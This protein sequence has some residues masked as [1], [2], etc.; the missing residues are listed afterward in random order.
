M[1]RLARCFGVAFTAAL[2]GW[3]VFD[4]PFWKAF[5]RDLGEELKEEKSAAR[6]A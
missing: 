5:W 6:A 4:L 2:E 1:R 3:W